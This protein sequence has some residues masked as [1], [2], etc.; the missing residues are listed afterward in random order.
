VVALL[1][2]G[3]CGSNADDLGV[4]AQC[5]SNDQ[6]DPDTHQV[7]L[8]FKGG[9]CG[10]MNCAHDTDCPELAKCVMHTDGM[11]YCFRTCLDKAECNAN[12]DAA[13]EANCSSSVTFVDNNQNIKACVP[14][15]S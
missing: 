13:N 11:N 7:C 8:N 5:T 1:F 6:C 10:I 2:A 15:S 4:G 3:A 14:P 9:Y 12:R